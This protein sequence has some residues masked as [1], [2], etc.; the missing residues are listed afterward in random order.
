MKELF[1]MKEKLK[2]ELHDLIYQIEREK[3]Y[4]DA[5]V[6]QELEESLSDVR[7]KYAKCLMQIKLTESFYIRNNTEE[8]T[9]E[10]GKQK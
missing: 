8:D 6:V 1:E 9:L 10:R 5:S 4:G 7:S 3:I 2:A